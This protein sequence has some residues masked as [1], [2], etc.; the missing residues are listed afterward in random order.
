M[1]LGNLTVAQFENEI[2]VGLPEP[3]RA[4]FAR[5]RCDDATHV[6]VGQWH[7]FRH[8][9]YI[10]CGDRETMNTILQHLEPLAEQMERQVELNCIAGEPW[11]EDTNADE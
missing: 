7:C 11:R 9:L 2:G 5:R 4:E 10:L 1:M 6:P 8:P 3:F